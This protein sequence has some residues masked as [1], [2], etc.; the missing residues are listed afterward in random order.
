VGDLALW[1]ANFYDNK[2]GGGAV[3]IKKM[4]TPGLLETGEPTQYAA[5]LSIR[6]HSGLPMIAHNGAWM[7]YRTSMRRYPEQHLSIVMLSNAGSRKVR[8]SQIANLYMEGNFIPSEQQSQGY[9]API[10]ID[11]K[12]KVLAGHEGVYWNESESL[13]RTIEIRDGKLHYVRSADSATELGAL[14][15]NSFFMVGIESPVSIEFQGSGESRTM[16]V[17]VDHEEPLLFETLPALSENVLATYT[18]DYWSTELRRELQ[19]SVDGS[20]IIASWAD[21]GTRTSGQLV[22]I[23]D[24]LF[25]Q[26]VSVPWYPQDI[27][28]HIEHNESGAITGLSL[29]CDMVRGVSFEKRP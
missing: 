27:R 3:L 13:L 10:A 7:G 2:L 19:L 22:S 11:L 23:N 21:D 28:L 6:T 25:P 8:S 12:A 1:D 15:D 14:E 29:S 18:G 20:E 4:E 26:F 9:Q 5:G 17:E 24:I 16:A